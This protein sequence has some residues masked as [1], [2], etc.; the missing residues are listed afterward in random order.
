[1]KR[2]AIAET[3]ERSGAPGEEDSDR[4][5]RPVR[6]ATFL[7][8]SLVLGA[9]VAVPLFSLRH[10]GTP[11]SP[12]QGSAAPSFGDGSVSFGQLDCWTTL[13]GGKLSACATTGRF[14]DEDVKQ[15]AGPGPNADEGMK[16]KVEQILDSLRIM[17]TPT[18]EPT[19]SQEANSRGS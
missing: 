7:A 19:T 18:S 11:V 9:A 12:H 16:T 17:I 2:P 14:D 3:R 15:A 6:I 13:Q 10:L 8:A 5:R 1:M 4:K